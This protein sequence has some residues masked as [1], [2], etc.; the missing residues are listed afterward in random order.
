MENQ[1]N[2]LKNAITTDEHGLNNS[3][4]HII[5]IERTILTYPASIESRK[6]DRYNYTYHSWSGSGSVKK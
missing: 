5:D 3:R 4:T 1:Y 6:I 2:I